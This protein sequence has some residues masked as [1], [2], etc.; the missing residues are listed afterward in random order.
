M[1]G[2]PAARASRAAFLVSA[3]AAIG[4]SHIALAATL[5]VNSTADPGVAGDGQ[6][7]L[8][9]A[10]ANA[11]SD[12]D[13]TAGDCPAGAGVDLVNVPAGRYV[14]GFGSLYGTSELI[15]ARSAGS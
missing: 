2:L 13:T 12:S 4:V 9:E 14:T 6:C 1:R 5:N 8:R 11:N 3:F 10:L 7:T 15:L